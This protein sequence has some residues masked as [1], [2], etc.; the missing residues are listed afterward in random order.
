MGKVEHKRGNNVQKDGK[1]EKRP[2]DKSA[3]QKKRFDK[4]AMVDKWK[5]KRETFMKHRYKKLQE[6]KHIMSIDC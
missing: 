1:K 2:F 3:F 6:K 5:S 4:K